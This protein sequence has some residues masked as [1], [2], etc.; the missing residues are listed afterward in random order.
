MPLPRCL[1]S[2]PWL[3]GLLW[4]VATLLRANRR[5]GFWDLW[6]HGLPCP[7][8][9]PSGE[10]WPSVVTQD[11]SAHLRAALIPTGQLWG[12]GTEG[13]PTPSSPSGGGPCPW[14]PKVGGQEGGPCAAAWPPHRPE[15]APSCPLGGA[16]L[17]HAPGRDLSR[18]ESLHVVRHLY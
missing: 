15:A 6:S 10:H 14:E 11:S 18:G 8:P 13:L 17:S 12:G 5:R 9:R 4:D 16:C 7:S 3:S 2:L 1:N